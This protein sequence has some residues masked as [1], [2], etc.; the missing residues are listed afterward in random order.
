M[1]IG[2]SREEQLMQPG[3][4]GDVCI[5]AM[6][7]A[8]GELLLADYKHKR[9]VA[10]DA[11]GASSATALRGRHVFSSDWRISAVRLVRAGCLAVLECSSNADGTHFHA[12]SRETFRPTFWRNLQTLK[13][14]FLEIFLFVR[15]S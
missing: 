11:P 8:G 6:C 2:R 15:T 4:T 12:S 5:V 7:V 9:V 1:E 3:E 10:L 14:F 13:T